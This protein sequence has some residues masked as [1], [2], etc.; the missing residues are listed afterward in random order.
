MKPKKWSERSWSDIHSGWQFRTFSSN[1]NIQVVVSVQDMQ[2]DGM[3]Q[4]CVH[5]FKKALAFEF[6]FNGNKPYPR[7]SWT[8]RK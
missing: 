5:L 4:V 7:I 1:R 6:P 8:L 3:A 2:G